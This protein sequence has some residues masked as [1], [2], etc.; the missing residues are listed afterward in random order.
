MNIKK[1]DQIKI[2]SGNDKGRTGTVTAAYPARGMIAAEG[3]NMRKK[4][5]RPRRQGDRGEMV[6]IPAPFPASRAMLVCPHCGKATRIAHQRDEAGR[7]S[8]VCRTCQRVI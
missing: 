8:R 3:L 2:I 1:G 6:R 7:G 4:H 5:V